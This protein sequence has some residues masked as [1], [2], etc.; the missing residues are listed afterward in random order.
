MQNSAD[1][2]KLIFTSYLPCQQLLGLQL[3]GLFV[4][5]LSLIRLLHLTGR[6]ADEHPCIIVVLLKLQNSLKPCRRRSRDEIFLWSRATLLQFVSRTPETDIPKCCTYASILHIC[7][8]ERKLTLQC[9]R[10][11]LYSLFFMASLALFSAAFT[12]LLDI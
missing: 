1:H 9:L 5:C 6:Q 12:S 4:G 10:A 7:L 2:Y 8:K 3:Q 11:S